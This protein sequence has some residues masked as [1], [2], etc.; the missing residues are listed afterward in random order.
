MQLDGASWEKNS[1]NLPKN[2]RLKVAQMARLNARKFSR[3]NV[4]PDQRDLMLVVKREWME[5][6]TKLYPH[7]RHL[8]ADTVRPTPKEP[9]FR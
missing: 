6:V 9:R 2:L 7:H 8:K 5:S 1:F 3:E 4:I